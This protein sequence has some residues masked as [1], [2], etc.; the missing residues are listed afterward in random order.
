[1]PIFDKSE[2]LERIEKTKYRMERTGI[3]VLVVV[4]PANMNY[5]T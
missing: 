3:E 5:L 4:D 1:M 2:Y